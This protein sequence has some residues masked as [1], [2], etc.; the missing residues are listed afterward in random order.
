MGVVAWI[1]GIVAALG[2]GMAGL[3]KVTWQKQMEEAAEHL[4]FSKQNFQAIGAAELA[5]AVGV[6][7]G[8]AVDDLEWIGIAAAIGLTAVGVG[9][10]MNHRRVGDPP[11]AMVPPAVLTVV[12]LISVISLTLR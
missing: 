1:T 3:A 10:V 4:S 7:L 6:I 12:A 9:A 2:F 5:G 11:Q 8:T